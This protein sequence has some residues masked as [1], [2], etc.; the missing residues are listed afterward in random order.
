MATP[1]M[2]AVAEP[3]TRDRFAGKLS[4]MLA[5]KA[6]ESPLLGMVTAYSRTSPTVAGSV[7][8]LSAGETKRSAL[9]AVRTGSA[10]VMLAVV[11]GLP[12]VRVAALPFTRL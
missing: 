5:S 3:G 8:C 11:P 2:L 12:L 9:A 10:S 6:V 4:T 1:S 7:D